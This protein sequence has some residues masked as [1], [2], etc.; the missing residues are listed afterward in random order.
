MLTAGLEGSGRFRRAAGGPVVAGA[1]IKGAMQVTVK[2]MSNFKNWTGPELKELLDLALRVK[3]NQPQYWKALDHLTL[4]MIFQKTS[5]RTRVSFE[6]AMT[7]LGGHAIYMDWR[8]TNLV[9]AEM[10]DEI[11]YLSRNVDAIMAR[12]L[13]FE[14]V[15]EMANYS[16]V[17]V[18]N[19]CDNKFHPTQALADFLT[20]LEHRGTLE[21][22]NL[23]Y[24]G[25]H[26]NVANSLIEGGTKLG[27]K[28]T[29]VTPEINEA[30]LDQEILD[31]AAA[32]GLYERTLDLP[33]AVA[34]ADVV[35]TDTWVDME[36]FMDPKFEAEKQRRI[37]KMLPYQLNE[38][39][40]KESKALIMHD[41]PIHP[42]YEITRGVIEHPNAVIFDQAEN[43]L[44]AEKAVLLKVLGKA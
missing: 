5:T 31:E 15:Q 24:V 6:V 28:I 38:E 12:V 43:R 1:S 20:V 44:H 30:S 40:L 35:Y 11:R 25:I 26:N 17:P 3:R 8:S 19:G 16:R 37:E 33:A 39:L 41:M 34:K 9:L 14:Q 32:T 18:I 13:T 2:H 36:F 29:M 4:G 10:K 7:Q 22:I 27:M 23:V 21:G 42:D